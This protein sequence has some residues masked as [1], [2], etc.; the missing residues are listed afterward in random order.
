MSEEFYHELTDTQWKMVA[1]NLPKPKATVLVKWRKKNVNW[2][3]TPLYVPL[4]YCNN[5]IK[6]FFQRIKQYR[7][8]MT[9]WQF[10]SRT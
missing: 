6:K 4:I 5:F 3:F 7:H 9:N 2:E 1:Q 10:F 8:V